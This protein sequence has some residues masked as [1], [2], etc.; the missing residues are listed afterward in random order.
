MFWYPLLVFCSLF[1]SLTFLGPD[2]FSENLR[3][4][5]AQ[6]SALR[7][8]TVA[9]AYLLLLA[10]GGLWR[11]SFCGESRLAR[12]LT[13]VAQ[14]ATL[15]IFLIK[16]SCAIG[17]WLSAPRTAEVRLTHCRPWSAVYL[18]HRAS[19]RREIS[20]TRVTVVYDNGR[21]WTFDLQG[22]T[23]LAIDSTATLRYKQ[24]WFYSQP[25]ELELQGQRYPAW[26]AF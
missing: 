13:R 19:T 8:L 2:T 6:L 9:L 17:L 12:G 26:A 25:V 10:I 22:Q 23:T 7:Q 16:I 15:F 1:L 11:N 20:A 21:P 3:I 5:F 14:L 4:E 18:G 24:A